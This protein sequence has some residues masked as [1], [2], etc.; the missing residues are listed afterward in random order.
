MISEALK[1]PFMAGLGLV[2]LL[3]AWAAYALYAKAR[4]NHRTAELFVS[5]PSVAGRVIESRIEARNAN[6]EDSSFIPRVRYAY[7]VGHTDF[8]NDVLRIGLRDF[9]YAFEPQATAH[10]AKYPLG[11]DVIVFYQK[12]NPGFSTLEPGQTG[13]TR[14]TIAAA[15]LLVVTVITLGSAIWIGLLP[16]E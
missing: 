3:F 16:T 10:L 1:L 12:D 15:L 11:G 5:A 9:G 6:S 8:E 7:R 2:A 14:L 13:A 4:R